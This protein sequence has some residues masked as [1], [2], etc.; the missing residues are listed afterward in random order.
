MEPIHYVG[1]AAPAAL[2]FQNGTLDTQ[3]RP[4]DTLRYQRAGSEPKTIRWYEADHSLN[5]QASLDTARWLGEIVGIAGVRMAFPTSLRVVLAVWFLLTL[6]SLVCLACLAGAL[7]TYS[8]HWWLIRRGVIR[9]G[10]DPTGPVK[11]SPGGWHGI[12]RPPS[13]SWRSLC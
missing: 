2:L 5:M 13:S 7:L 11:R 12:S 4:A 6:I 8:F 3:V 1:C 9:W 10:A